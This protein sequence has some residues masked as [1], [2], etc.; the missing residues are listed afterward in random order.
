MKWLFIA[1]CMVACSSA[2]KDAYRD[3]A[4]QANPILEAMRPAA[5]RVLASDPKDDRAVIAACMSADDELWKLRDV[6]FDNEYV[7]TLPKYDRVSLH[8]E[9]LLDARNVNCRDLPPH[10]LDNCARWCRWE[11]TSMIDTVEVIRTRA[12]SEGVDIVSLKP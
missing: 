1:S 9:G 6:R 12:K 5:A 7:D 8:V 10:L 4:R 3:L 2:K 11:W